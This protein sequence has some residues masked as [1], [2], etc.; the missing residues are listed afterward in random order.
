MKKLVTYPKF[1]LLFEIS[2]KV[3]HHF[4]RLNA[5]PAL[6]QWKRRETLQQEALT[7]RLKELFLDFLCVS[8]VCFVSFVVNG[9]LG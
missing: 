6:S 9:F 5:L 2:L 1:E 8:F 3:L 7:N 4:G